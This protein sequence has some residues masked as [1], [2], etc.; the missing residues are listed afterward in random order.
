MSLCE[1]TGLKFIPFYTMTRSSR[2]QLPC[3]TPTRSRRILLPSHVNYD[4]SLVESYLSED[5]DNNLSFLS[6][7]NDYSH[8]FTAEGEAKFKSDLKKDMIQLQI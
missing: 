7:P 1:H 5:N 4:D 6:E 3:Y 2:I 8:P